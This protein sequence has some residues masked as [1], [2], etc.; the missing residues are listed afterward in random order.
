MKYPT[1]VSPQTLIEE[2]KKYLQTYQLEEAL[3]IIN[4]SL[5]QSQ[6]SEGSNLSLNGQ[7]VWCKILLTK[8]RFSG[9]EASSKLALNKLEDCQ[10]LFTASNNDTTIPLPLMILLT[11]AYYQLGDTIKARQLAQQLLLFSKTTQYTIGKIEAY[12]LLGQIALLKQL[13]TKALAFARDAQ[14]LLIQNAQILDATTLAA[15]YDLL[16]DIFLY[17]KEYNQAAIYGRK[18]L[19]LIKENVFL[20]EVNIKAHITLGVCAISE[21]NHTIA[22]SFLLKAKELAIAID[23]KQL[24]ASSLL[25]IAILYNKVRYSQGALNC[26]ETIAA[27]YEGILKDKATKLV[28]QNTWGQTL[29]DTHQLE[30]ATTH[31]EIVRQIANPITDKQA[32]IIAL[33]HLSAIHTAKKEFKKALLLAKRAN[34]YIEDIAEDVTGQALNLINLGN[35]HYQLGKFSEAIKLTSRGIATAK[36]QREEHNEIRGY[37]IMSLIFQKQKNYKNALLYQMIYTKFFE[38]FFQKNERQMLGNFEAAFTL[39]TL[40]NSKGSSK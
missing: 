23:Q 27:T 29:Y 2:S 38:D 30:E 32:N 33:V 40:K 1:T 16:S 13:P 34:E 9:D 19:Q 15:N 37:Q 17:Q 39:Q 20:K 8:G 26:L 21:D 25:Q 24:I 18:L 22:L 6:L 7:I 10:Q 11:K 3:S 12:N 14:E 36:R 4:R 35:I 31:F 5:L 28:F